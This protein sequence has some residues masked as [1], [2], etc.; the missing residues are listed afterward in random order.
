MTLGSALP[1]RTCSSPLGRIQHRIC[2]PALKKL[3]AAGHGA[4][5]HT[6]YTST[7]AEEPS[8]SAPPSPELSAEHVAA[9]ALS[10]LVSRLSRIP[11]RSQNE[12]RSI[13]VKPVGVYPHR[14]ETR[15]ALHKHHRALT[16]Q[17]RLEKQRRQERGGDWRIILHHLMRSTVPDAK[18]HGHIKVVIPRH[19]IGSLLSDHRQNLW[20]IKSRTGCAVTLYRPTDE[21]ANLDP[22][23]T[24]E[25]QLASISTAVDDILKVTKGITVVNMGEIQGIEQNGSQ[26]DQAPEDGAVDSAF[27]ATKIQ[28]HQMTV[29]WRPYKL[30]IRADQIPR[31]TEWTTEAFQQY[32]AALVMG[33]VDASLARRLYPPGKTHKEATIQQLLEAFNDPNA[34]H[35]ISLPALIMAL[36]YLSTAGATYL[37]EVRE[38]IERASGLGLRMDTTIYNLLADTAVYCKNLLAFETA[39]SQMIV[40]GHKPNLRTWLLFLRMIEAEDIRRYIIQAM[41]IKGFLSD[42]LTVNQVSGVMADHDA[43]RAVQEG[44]NIGAFLAGLRDLYGETWQ[45]HQRAACRYLD[46]F[47]QYSKFDESRQLLEYMFTTKHG[48]PN[49]IALNTVL[50]HCKHQRKVDLAVAFVRMFDERRYNVADQVTFQLLYEI[51]RRVQKPQLLGAV[52]RYAHRLDMTNHDMRNHGIKLLAGKPDLSHLTRLIRGIWEGPHKCPISR[53]EF[54]EGLLLCDYSTIRS[55]GLKI[56]KGRPKKKRALIKAALPSAPDS[57]PIASKKAYVDAGL[58]ELLESSPK[59]PPEEP[60]KESPE[61]SQ[62]SSAVLPV[63]EADGAQEGPEE[64]AATLYAAEA[65]DLYS[66]AVYKSVPKVAPAVPLGSVLQAA[67]DIDRRLNSLSREGIAPAPGMRVAADL[68]PVKLPVTPRGDRG[69][70]ARAVLAWLTKKTEDEAAR[71]K[72]QELGVIDV[73]GAHPEELDDWSTMLLAGYEAK[74]GKKYIP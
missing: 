45:L 51:A 73:V 31:P 61:E 46:V 43:Y 13:V 5:F 12:S 54:I 49:A 62:P 69:L 16:Q 19:S 28:P 11:L 37:M 22:Y 33:D 58:G 25:G 15:E 26:A 10:S 70:G 39:V 4:F 30:D 38:L 29:S 1:W 56:A 71:A 44:Q 47:G 18:P 41:A 63:G 74:L 57:E 7:N 55:T 48:R 34:W 64:Q 59:G 6:Q 24:L 36:R 50:T 35:V 23:V 9:R 17:V 67:L 40:H 14:R 66:K 72:A 42:P 20:N 52:W 53:K 68:Y 27:T 21:G 2:L 8:K 60:P 32:V 3:Q 65:Y